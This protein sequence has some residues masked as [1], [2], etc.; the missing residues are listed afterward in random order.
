MQLHGYESS[1]MA[2]QH[3]YHEMPFQI[4]MLCLMLAITMINP[5]LIECY[6]S[7]LR[8]VGHHLPSTQCCQHYHHQVDHPLPLHMIPSIFYYFIKSK[9]PDD[10]EIN[11][12]ALSED[13]ELSMTKFA[14]LLQSISKMAPKYDVIL[15]NC[16]WY[17]GAVCDCVHREYPYV[18]KWDNL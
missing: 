3:R 15:K 7:L 9:E 17:A 6:Y 5:S 11:I 16:Y 2:H 13:Q 14:V 10:C 8:M 4:P 12:M 1:A 18:L